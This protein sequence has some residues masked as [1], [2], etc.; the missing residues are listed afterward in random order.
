MKTKMKILLIVTFSFIFLSMQLCS[1]VLGN[2]PVVTITSPVTNQQVTTSKI[3]VE[4]TIRD[5]DG[6]QS[7]VEVWIEDKNI[8]ATDFTVDTGIFDVELDLSNL[9]AGTYNIMVQRYDKNNNVSEIIYVS[10]KYDI[11]QTPSGTIIWN[12]ITVPGA[13]NWRT[14]S[15]SDDGKYV[16][17]VYIDGYIYISNDYGNSW[18]EKTFAGKN[19]GVV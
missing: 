2:K 13:N 1:I 14:I 12:K 4:G 11:N 19:I 6:D 18:S 5:Q 10:I 15:T 3:D 8:K 17:A 9:T 16:A 7:K